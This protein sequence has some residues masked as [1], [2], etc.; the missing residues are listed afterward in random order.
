VIF[1]IRT[2][3]IARRTPFPRHTWQGRG[4]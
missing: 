1:S 3:Y 2:A 4:S